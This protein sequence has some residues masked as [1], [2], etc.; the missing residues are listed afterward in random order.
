MPMYFPDLK[1]LCYAAE[2]HQFRQPNPH[3][4]EPDYRKALADHVST[5]DIVE[6]EEIRNGVGW[7][8]WKDA[9]KS[10]FLVRNTD[11]EIWRERP[12][13]YYS[14]SIHVTE[15]GGIG[16]N[17]GGRVIVLSA[18]EWHCLANNAGSC[19][20]NEIFSAVRGKCISDE[21][22]SAA[23][24]EVDELV[25]KFIKEPSATDSHTYKKG[26]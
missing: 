15:H 16:I 3:E 11:Q 7:D 5:R 6:S 1:S 12:E 22:A 18:K 23:A 14:D 25:K 26:I 21:S 4:A 17:C 13:D 2:V 20:F 19:H 8:Q 9:Q 24:T 10:Q